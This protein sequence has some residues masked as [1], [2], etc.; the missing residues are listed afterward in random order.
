MGNNPF[1]PKHEDETTTSG[2]AL[3]A[4]EQAEY[5][6]L[7]A[8]ERNDA[9]GDEIEAD[10]EYAPDDVQVDDRDRD[11]PAELHQGDTE[12]EQGYPIENGAVRWDDAA[13]GGDTSRQA[14]A[15]YDTPWGRRELSAAEVKDFEHQGVKVTRVDGEP[16]T[17]LQDE[18]DEMSRVDLNF[19][20]EN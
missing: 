6:R 3:T 8:L 20:P 2:R 19:R 10:R 5:G 13:N 15:T 12:A 1:A 7:E 11:V 4:D 16:T 9:T 14:T 18:R 17:S